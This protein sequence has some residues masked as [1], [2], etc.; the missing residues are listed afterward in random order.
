MLENKNAPKNVLNRSSWPNSFC[1]FVLFQDHIWLCSGLTPDPELRKH[2]WWCSGNAIECHRLNP[3]RL[4]SKQVHYPL[5][6]LVLI[7]I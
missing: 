7:K 2:T 6:V 4:C 1:L 3:S 5:V